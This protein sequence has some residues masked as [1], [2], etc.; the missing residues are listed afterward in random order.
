MRQQIESDNSP[1]IAIYGVGF[2]GQALVRLCH[3]KGWEIVAAYNRAGDKT[4]KDVGAISEVGED[5]GIIVQDSALVHLGNCSADIALI[6]AG[7][8]LSENM[9]A[10]RQFLSAGIDVLC[11]GSES[12]SPRLTNVELAIEIDTLAKSHNATF[13]GG[14]IWD[15]TRL[16]SGMIAAGPCVEIASIEHSSTTEIVRQGEQYLKLFGVGQAQ[17]SFKKI[18]PN[19]KSPWTFFHIPGVFVLEKLGYSYS[20]HKNWVEPIIWDEAV[21]CTQLGATIKP[22]QIVG[23]RLRVDVFSKE[24]VTVEN[25]FDYRVFKPGEIE[26]MRWRIN[27]Q[28]SFEINVVREGSGLASASSLFNRIPDVLAAGPGIVE[29]PDLL[30]LRPNISC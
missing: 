2:V 10:Y 4:G 14:G 22:G 5:I 3:S 26:E 13:M 23:A 25:R 18:F 1:K 16:W 19:G 12:Y 15:M 30:P 29:I 8:T 21:E 20:D 6:A 27:G 9:D 24:G 17:E 7:N 28:P 11:H